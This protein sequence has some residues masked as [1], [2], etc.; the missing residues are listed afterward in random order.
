[1]VEKINLNKNVFTKTGFTNT[2]DTSFS[3]LVVPSTQETP[4]MTVE[5]FFNFY[6]ELFF[7]IPKEG[8]INSHQYLVNRS[9]A[10]IEFD[11]VNEEIQAL[12]EEISQLRQENLQLNQQINELNS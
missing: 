5:E 4:S 6:E 3:Q 9:G 8:I 11:R 1:M 7:Q 10:Y 12:L 2:V